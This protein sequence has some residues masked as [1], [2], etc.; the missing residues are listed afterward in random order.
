MTNEEKIKEK[1]VEYQIL[2]QQ[3]QQLQENINFLEKRI[4]DLNLIYDHLGSIT[5][6]EVGKEI[7]VPLGEGIFLKGRLEDTE[8]IIMNISSGI[9]IEK[10]RQEAG[11]IIIKQIEEIRNLL[12]QIQN[13]AMN[14][15][16]ALQELQNILTN[17][18]RE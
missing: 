16:L 15:T 18:K 3:L 2:V 4:L 7:L 1:Y 8:K 17:M 6:T 13:E 5:E 14:T 12:A 9:F 11:E 10:T